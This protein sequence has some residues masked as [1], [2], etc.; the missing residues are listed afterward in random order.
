MK[1]SF[2]ALFLV[3]AMLL[4]SGCVQPVQ[5][6]VDSPQ[7]SPERDGLSIAVTFYP[8][9]EA[10]RMVTGDSAEVFSVIPAFS[11]PHGYE[12][13]PRQILAFNRADVFVTM[14]LEFE[15]LEEDLI[16]SAENLVVINAAEGIELIEGEEHDHDEEG[17]GD[18]DDGD[19]EES[20]GGHGE[21]EDD[22]GDESD[23]HEEEEDR[24]DDEADEN[25]EGHDE[26]EEEEHGDEDGRSGKDPH[27]WLS[28][29]NVK[30]MVENV[31]ERLV[32]IDPENAA[33]YGQNAQESINR[34]TELD[35]EFRTGLSS[36]SKDVVLVSH[37]AFSYLARDYGFEIVGLSGLSPEAEPTPQQIRALVDEAREHDLKY[38]FYEEFVD[39]RVSAAI[40][41]E[42]GAEVLEL[43]PLEGTNDPE[44]TYFSI[45]GK[46]LENLKT[47]MECT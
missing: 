4:L 38:V 12:P 13:S 29:E 34:L 22:H 26:D 11:E 31:K 47:A 23:E 37:N 41:R 6:P 42:V 16:S 8:L 7:E 28:P 2:M 44:A 40:A 25:G 9:Q 32:E 27:I 15:N 21:E 43:N 3:G 5:E 30:Q 20:E 14:G 39:P 24:H 18:E 1:N 19:H 17:H 45:M 10:V 33:L 36:C 35:G 46:N